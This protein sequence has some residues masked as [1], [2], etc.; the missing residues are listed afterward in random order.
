M[1]AR[2]A[3]RKSVSEC[4]VGAHVQHGGHAGGEALGQARGARR[5]PRVSG[6]SAA[7]PGQTCARAMEAAPGP[8]ARCAGASGRG[9]GAPERSRAGPTCPGR[10]TVRPAPRRRG[11]PFRSRPDRQDR[12]RPR[13]RDPRRRVRSP[14][15][16]GPSRRPPDE[17]QAAHRGRR[18]GHAAHPAGSRRTIRSVRS[19]RERLAGRRAPR[20]PG[21]AARRP[22]TASCGRPGSARK[23]LSRGRPNSAPSGSFASVTPS[24]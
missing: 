3:A 12:C 5:P 19:S 9:G 17:K 11:A 22:R 6:S 8:R 10:R 18:T 2:A 1:P 14:D 23:S 13:R 15:R 20:G 21:P 16:R 7:S 24:V 4:R